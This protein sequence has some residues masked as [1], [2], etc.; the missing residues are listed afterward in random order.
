MNRSHRPIQQVAASHQVQV[1]RAERNPVAAR[2]MVWIRD[3][4][5]TM[6][7]DSVQPVGTFMEAG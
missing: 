4:P 6:Q 1:G 5:S 3:G 7:T 2:L